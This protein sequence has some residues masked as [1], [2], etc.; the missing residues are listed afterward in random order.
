LEWLPADVYSTRS[1]PHV[2]SR[3]PLWDQPELAREVEAGHHYLPGA[4]TG[5]RETL[6]TTAVEAAPQYVIRMPGPGWAHFFAAAFTAAFFLLLTVKLVTPA[7]IC[8]VLAIVAC[9]VWV[10]SLDLGPSA[11]V[12]EVAEGLRLPTYM[13]GPSSHAWWAMVVLMLVA[14]SLYLAYIFS[15]L[16]L[17]TVSPEVWPAANSSALP[18]AAWPLGSAALLLAGA[19]AFVIAGRSLPAQGRRL[20]ASLPL[21]FLGVGCL[22]A[23]I[24][25]EIFGH[26]QAS[27]RPGESAYGALVYLAAGLNGQLVFAVVIMGLF[28]MARQ[29]AGRLDDV[30]RSS[31]ENTALLVYYTVGQALL[32]LALVHGFPRA[33]G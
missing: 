14:G 13:T 19:I 32:G 7:V 28:T 1:I 25:V 4:P 9:L 26:W 10:W 18:G 17:W 29:I 22:V 23:A 8:G 15:Y 30:R 11:G 5:G 6:V 21:V 27:V 16:Y 12:V 33:V 31:F 3:E 2:T 24:A 20:T